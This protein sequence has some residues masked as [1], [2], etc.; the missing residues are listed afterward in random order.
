VRRS[1]CGA[2]AA[3]LLAAALIASGCG[4]GGAT[5]FSGTEPPAAGG[6]GALRYAIPATPEGLDPLRAA[7]LS[8]R[9]V[10]LQI[11]EP[12]VAVLDAPYGAARS[13]RGLALGWRPSRDFRVWSFRLRPGVQFQDGTPFNASV[14]LT[15]AERW[16]ASSA[17]RALLPGL[18]AAD[19]PRP[20][21]ARLILAVPLRDLPERLQNA[22]LGLV[23]PAAL[24]PSEGGLRPLARVERA[25]SGPFEL[26]AR[27][28][29]ELSL[30]RHR[31]WWGSRRG[32]GPALDQVLFSV[33]PGEFERAAQLRAGEVRVAAELGPAAA[34]S[35]QRD[36]LLAVVGAGSGHALG[37][38]R[39]VRGIEGRRPQPFS[40]VW[41]ALLGQAS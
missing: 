20:D 15:N 5:R 9:A 25:G 35:L 18:V 12:L 30:A 38:E 3:A 41:L 16:R 13:R 29:L 26:V 27:S 14:V 21:L 24:G 32:L 28:A 1:P 4:G 37:L 7:S 22:R 8:D 36:P 34:K 23:S 17:G 19:A 33:V 2:L 11:F 6:S 31:G 39:S 40:G 10:S